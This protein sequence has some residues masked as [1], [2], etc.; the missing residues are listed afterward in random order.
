[1]LSQAPY[2]K[3]NFIFVEKYVNQ[4]AI[5]THFASS[6]FKEFGTISAEMTSL[7]MEIKIYDI[8]AEK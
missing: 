4:A 7:P 3:T 6:Y 5:D 1:M 8:A 2:E